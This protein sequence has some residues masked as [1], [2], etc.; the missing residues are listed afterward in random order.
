[1]PRPHLHLGDAGAN[2]AN[3]RQHIVHAEINQSVKGNATSSGEFAESDVP[4]SVS[5]RRTSRFQPTLLA[6]TRSD[7]ASPT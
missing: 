1:M 4:S 5:T 6:F 2:V 3:I 7:S